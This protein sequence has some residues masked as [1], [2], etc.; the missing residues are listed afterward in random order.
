MLLNKFLNESS[1]IGDNDYE[2]EMT[3]EGFRFED[4]GISRII[5]LSES[6]MSE[7]NMRC[8]LAEVEAGKKVIAGATLSEAYMLQENVI[9]S[10]IGGIKK[11]IMKIW[12]RMKEVCE[13]VRMEFNKL[14]NTSAFL[15]DAKRILEKIND[16]KDLEFE[17]YDF[18]VDALD[19][20]SVYIASEKAVIKAYNAAESALNGVKAGE[21]TEATRKSVEAHKDVID[22]LKGDELK[23]KMT[24]AAFGCSPEDLN[25]T[26]FKKLRNGKDTEEKLSWDKNKCIK[27]IEELTSLQNKVKGVADSVNNAHK[28]ALNGVDESIKKAEKANGEAKSTESGITSAKLQILKDKATGLKSALDLS[29]I[30]TNAKLAVLKTEAAQSKKFISAAIRQGRKNERTNKVSESVDIFNLDNIADQY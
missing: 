14:F 11:I 25:K 12:A 15:K 9:S 5:S 3:N 20:N 23:K 6:A 7:I 28:K 10:A 27:A 4:G 19:A 16:F 29:N 22:A 2:V 21:D 30:A 24:E 13:A 8:Q 26:I 18:T 1:L 17:G